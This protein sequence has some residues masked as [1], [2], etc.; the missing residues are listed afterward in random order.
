ME[1]VELILSISVV[2]GLMIYACII[3]YNDLNYSGNN[4]S[5][6]NRDIELD[7][8]EIYEVNEEYKLSEQ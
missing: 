8:T 7:V 2:S 4:T 6:E 1:N 3:E 5:P